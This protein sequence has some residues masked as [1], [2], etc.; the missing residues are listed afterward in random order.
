MRVAIVLAVAYA[1]AYPAF[2]W[3]YY[4]LRRYPR[5]LWTGF[6]RPHPWRQATVV[7]YVAGGLPVVV[8]AVV[9][10][11]SAARRGM[12]DVAHR[13]DRDDP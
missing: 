1:V 3:T 2:A 9:W 13:A 11:T 4:D 7:S 10:R 5:Q 8:V 6:G 12:R